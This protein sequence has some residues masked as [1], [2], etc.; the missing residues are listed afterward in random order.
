MDSRASLDGCGKSRPPL[1]FD[2]R[3][4]QP[5]ASGYT[6]WTIPAPKSV[7]LRLA[8]TGLIRTLEVAENVNLLLT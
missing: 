4:V 7:Q 2:P 5:V 6:D 8:P 1:G 3:T